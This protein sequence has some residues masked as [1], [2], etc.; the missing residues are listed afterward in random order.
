MAKGKIVKLE[1]GEPRA[2]R[3]RK[4]LQERI[5]ELK[6]AKQAHLARAEK[7]EE[8]LQALLVEQKGKAEAIQAAVR[9]ARESE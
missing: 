5:A 2:P 4:I 9:G 7:V 1:P 3:Q 8:K 6:A